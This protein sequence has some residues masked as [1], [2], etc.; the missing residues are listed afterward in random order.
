MSAL[1]E[2]S[3]VV[4]QTVLLNDVSAKSGLS[5][6]HVNGEQGAFWL[7][8]IM[9]SGVGLLDM[10]DDS[11]LD[12]WFVQGG[13]LH[14]Q[15]KTQL[16]DQLYLN[17]G[18]TGSMTFEL[19]TKEYGLVADRYGLG[20]ATADIDNDGDTDVFLA[21]FGPNQLFK[22]ESGKFQ[23]VSIEAGVVDN[24]WSVSASFFHYNEDEFIDLYVV[25]YVDFSF[26]NH[27]ICLGIT[28]VPDYCTPN[29]YESLADQLLINQGDGTF[30]DA[31]EKSGIS[32]KQG[33]GLGV[34]ARDYNKDGL[35]DLYVANDATPNFLWVNVSA[36]KLVDHAIRSGS[37]VNIDGRAEA[38]MGVDA[39]DFDQDCDM[40]LFMTNLSGETNTVFVNGGEGWFRDRTRA[41][42]L[43]SSSLAF[44]G[45]GTRWVDLD[46]DGDLD[47]VSVNGTVSVN[48]QIVEENQTSPF[49]QLNQAWIY[50]QG[51]YVLNCEGAFCTTKDTSRGLAVGD[52]DND[53]DADLV[54]TNNNGMARIYENQTKGGNWIGFSLGKSIQP[55]IGT[56]IRLVDL[57]CSDRYF[58]TDGSYASASDPRVVFGLGPKSSN[59]SVLVRF[60]DGSEREYLDLKANKYH[61]LEK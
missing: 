30:Y 32:A 33:N 53:G 16:N 43:A 42:G 44:T 17:A 35:T 13:H 3:A 39:A 56:K 23:E 59:Q 20:I 25:N 1:F 14:A 9:G 27:R 31:S 40:D 10:N 57:P 37:A 46:N 58:S 38:S 47:I 6:S 61:L 24:A 15:E 34:V 51:K 18:I 45:F 50:E 36:S 48:A 2:S 19:V 54:V 52:L 55:T 11:F 28:T 49:A 12:I 21:N 41:E 29:V 22:N 8:E 26:E 7:P 4:A 60:P 5:F